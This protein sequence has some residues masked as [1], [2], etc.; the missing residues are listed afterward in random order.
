MLQHLIYLNFS[1][2]CIPEVLVSVHA[3]G[4]YPT[5]S[6][7]YLCMLRRISG[8]VHVDKHV[9]VQ[10][11][12]QHVCAACCPACCPACV[13]AA[14]MCAACCPACVRAACCPAFMCAACCPACV[15]QHV[16]QHLCVQHVCVQHVA[17]HVCRSSESLLL[18]VAAAAAAPPT[19]NF[20]T[21]RLFPG[22]ALEWHVTL[23]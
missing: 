22:H 17:Q 4:L 15:W 8:R 14:C 23:S 3:K 16:A 19:N 11:V 1:L 18:V 7:L 2:V 9:C 6:V 20:C 12:A 13:C 5:L 21:H 10:H